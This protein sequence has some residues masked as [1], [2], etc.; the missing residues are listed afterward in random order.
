MAVRG[1]RGRRRKIRFTAGGAGDIRR[2]MVKP[3]RTGRKNDGSQHHNDCERE[4]TFHTHLKARR[5]RAAT[6]CPRSPPHLPTFG[7]ESST[8]KKLAER[9][10]FEPSVEFPL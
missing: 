1:A 5:L 6:C 2:R 3:L 10:G 8:R 9:E 7:A 4:R